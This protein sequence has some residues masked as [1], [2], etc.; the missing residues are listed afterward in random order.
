MLTTKSALFSTAHA[1]PAMFFDI[2][3]FNTEPDEL[4][5]IESY[6]EPDPYL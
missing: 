6:S 4:I 2:D 3:W 5:E 1:I